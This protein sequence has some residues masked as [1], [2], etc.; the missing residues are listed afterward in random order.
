MSEKM[1]NQFNVLDMFKWVVVFVL[2]VGLVIVN[3]MY[4]EILVLYCV[5]VIVVV[6]GIVGF[7]VVIIEKGSIFLSFVKEFCIEVCKVVWLIC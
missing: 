4:G 3:I 7:I 5:I 6:V 2:F 1:E